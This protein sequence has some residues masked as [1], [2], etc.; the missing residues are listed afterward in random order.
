MTSKKRAS[1]PKEVIKEPTL[2]QRIA[3]LGVGETFSTT[4]RLEWDDA[5][6]ESVRE[7][8][9]KMR[10]T[11]QSATFRAQNRTGNTYTIEGGLIVTR[12]HDILVVVAVTRET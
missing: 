12:S 2:I 1:A 5:T 7:A 11:L 4:T 3:S 9:E 6:K 10:N 8:Q